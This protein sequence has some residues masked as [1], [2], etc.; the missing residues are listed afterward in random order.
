M[1]GTGRIGEDDGNRQKTE[2]MMGSGGD[3]KMMQAD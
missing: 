1:M 3:G 2:R